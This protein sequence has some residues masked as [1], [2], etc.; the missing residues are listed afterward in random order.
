MWRT[1]GTPKCAI[2]PKCRRV[3]DAAIDPQ[4][5]RTYVIRSTLP[6][7]NHYKQIRRR[8]CRRQRRNSC[9]KWRLF[10]GTRLQAISGNW[11]KITYF[12]AGHTADCM[13]VCNHKHIYFA[14]FLF[15]PTGYPSEVFHYPSFKWTADDGGTWEAWNETPFAFGTSERA[16]GGM[17]SRK[18]P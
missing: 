3:G 15:M 11:N 10:S 4:F 13:S 1:Q 5:P 18:T 9:S 17:C 2:C 6:P 16:T 7:G 12:L 8:F 14:T